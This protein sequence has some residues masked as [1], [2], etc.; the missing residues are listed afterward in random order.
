M[1]KWLHK[2]QPQEVA[3]FL[4]R[5]Q[6]PLETAPQLAMAHALQVEEFATAC[7]LQ[8]GITQ[9]L[10]GMLNRRWEGLL[11]QHTYIQFV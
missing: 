4:P 5:V 9:L 11:G 10:L 1:K 6:P 2:S 8:M 7:A 3:R